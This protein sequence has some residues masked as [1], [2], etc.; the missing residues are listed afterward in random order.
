MPVANC[1]NCGEITNSAT[2]NYW[3]NTEPDGTTK[4]EIGTPTECYAA[5]VDG[6]LVKGCCYDDAEP[7]KQA[8]MDKLIVGDTSN[9][10]S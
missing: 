4:K 2:S 3:Q 7:H 8:I 1:K 6:K 5:F 9:G 10:K